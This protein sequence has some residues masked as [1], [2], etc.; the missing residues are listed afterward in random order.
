MKSGTVPRGTVH[1]IGAGLAGLAAAVRLCQAGRRAVVYEAAGQAGGRCR[2]Y[3]DETL[4][5]RIDNGNHL[6][7]SGNTAAMAYVAEI[8]AAATFE[9]TDRAEYNFLDLETRE[10]WSV[11]PT[12]GRLPWWLFLA[13]RR[14]AGT[15][16]FD[17]LD[18]F[19]LMRAPVTAT[20]AQTIATERAIY[21]RLWAPLAVAA[22][23]TDADR[24]S[25]RLMGEIFADTF[26]RGGAA[27]HPI[28][29]KEGL[30]E[31]LVDPAIAAIQ[32]KGG[33]VRFA[34][35]L[36]ALRF[37]GD[38]IAALDFGRGETAIGEDEGVVLAVTAP[39]AQDLV[40]ELTAPDA[41]GAIVN[42]HFKVEN[43]PGPAYSFLGLVGGTAEWIFLKPGIV[44]TTTSAADRLLDRDPD[45]VA[46]AIWRDVTRAY[47]LGR[48]PLPP[49]RIVREKRATFLATPDQLRRRPGTRTRWRNLL[50]AGDWTDTGW[51]ATIEGAIRSGFAAAGAALAERK[52]D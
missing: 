26:G 13:H 41:F 17:Y 23:N 37:D 7:V 22:L 33:E 6:L 10:R 8:G 4:G 48:A 51:P 25:A 46:A 19:R 28:F 35:R 3:F 49:S 2:S 27:L 16:L 11:R 12:E 31:S 21:R 32:A 20:I 14:V 15:G 42:A 5:C 34:Q 18:A 40:P 52:S 39:V 38:R 45:E 1:V 36:R 24:A 9:T 30:S 43:L 50:L 29:P 47:D 44:S